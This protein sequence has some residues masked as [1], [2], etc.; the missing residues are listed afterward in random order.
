MLKK[1]KVALR[2][3]TAVYDEE[4]K[5][6]INACLADLGLTDI[7]NTELDNPLITRA[8]ILYCKLHFGYNAD[9]KEAERLKATYD[10]LKASMSMSSDFTDWEVSDE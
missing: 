4:I 10:E 5:D 8:I 2:L 6:L 1:V 9:D 7:T 3:Q